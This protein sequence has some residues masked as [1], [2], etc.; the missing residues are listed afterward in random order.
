MDDRDRKAAEKAERM[1]AALREN[2]RRRKAQS[3]AVG[4]TPAPKDEPSS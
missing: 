3:R 4:A 1:A 2:L